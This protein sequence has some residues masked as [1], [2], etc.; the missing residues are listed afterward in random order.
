MRTAKGGIPRHNDEEERALAL[1]RRW[2]GGFELVCEGWASPV[3]HLW[4]LA[5]AGMTV[6][7]GDVKEDEGD[8]SG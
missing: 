4:V 3:S 1:S 7:E 8:I 2:R 5:C 6:V